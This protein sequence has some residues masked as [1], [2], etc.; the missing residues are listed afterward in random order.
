M[1]RYVLALL[2]VPIAAGAWLALGPARPSKSRAPAGSAAAVQPTVVVRV[3]PAAP[4]EAKLPRAAPAAP[5]PRAAAVTSEADL[6]RYLGTLE[7]D[8]RARGEVRP[9]DYQHGGAA[10][11]RLQSVLGRDRAVVMAREFGRRLHLL[12]GALERKPITNQLERQLASLEGERD[13]EARRKLAARY[14]AVAAG[15]PGLYRTEALLRLES[16]E[17]RL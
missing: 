8:A 17:S 12:S 6:T 10:V 4:T 5:D 15:L 3:D 1:R 11:V 16:A 14:R 2:V 9:E 13:P 7:N